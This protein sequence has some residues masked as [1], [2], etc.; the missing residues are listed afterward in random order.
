[1]AVGEHL[2]SGRTVLLAALAGA[3]AAFALGAFYRA[4]AV[5]TMSVVAP[6]SASGVTLPVAV[7]IATGDRPSA[8]QAVG[9]ALTVVG[10]VLA[11]REGGDGTARAASRTAVGLSLVAAIGIG[12]FFTISDAAA[13]DSVLWLL[14]ISRS[15]AVVVIAA[16]L[17]ASRTRPAV[18]GARDLRTLVAVGALDLAATGLYG[19]ANTKGLLSIVAVVGSLYPV[20]TVLLARFVLSERLRG[21]QAAGVALAFGGVAA[22]A[23]GG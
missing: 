16:V 7:G 19:V 13:D 18:P 9:L 21:V 12:A 11:S 22:V 2:P 17:V 15:T 8:L 1:M 6:I 5:G 4:L 20:T 10:V 3:A 23:G 14:V